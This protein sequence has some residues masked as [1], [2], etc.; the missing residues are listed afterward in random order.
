VTVIV[1]PKVPWKHVPIGA[2]LIS[3]LRWD[4]DSP[5]AITVGFSMEDEE[6]LWVFGRDLV[7]EAKVGRHAGLGNVKIIIDGSVLTLHLRSPFGEVEL[8]T[9]SAII[10]GFVMRTFS[11]VPAGEEYDYLPWDTLADWLEG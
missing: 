5:L 9:N 1:E 3:W 11:L 7:T 4:S 6:V 10:E 8:Q 2:T